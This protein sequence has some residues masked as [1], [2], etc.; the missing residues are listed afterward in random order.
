MLTVFELL[1]ITAVAATTV[2]ITRFFLFAPRAAT[3]PVP[4]PQAEPLSLLFDNGVLHHASTAALKRFS[5]VPGRHVWEDLRDAL[6]GQFPDLPGSDAAGKIKLRS[7][8]AG[9]PLEIE[10][11]WRDGLCWVHLYAPVVADHEVTTTPPQPS[12][13]RDCINTMPHPAWTTDAEGRVIWTNDAYVK[14]AR[15]IGNHTDTTKDDALF[16]LDGAS[17]PQRCVVVDATGENAWFEVVR[18]PT[19]D[20]HINHATPITGL[21]HA[22]EAQRTFVQ[23]LAKTFAHLPVGLAIFDR[24]G[25]LGIFNPAL[26]DL[27]GLQASFLATQ[28]TMLG[29]F[30]A[31]RENRRMPEPKNYQSWRQD[32][33]DVIAAASGG[34]YHETWS[35]E[36]GRTYAVQGRPHPD[37][38]TAFLI[39]DISADVTLSRSYRAEIEQFE[40][41][42][43]TVDEALVVF[44][45]SGILTFCN[46]AYRVMWGQTPEAAFADVTIHDAVKLWKSK[47]EDGTKLSGLIGFSTSIGPRPEQRFELSLSQGDKLR[48]TLKT[49]AADATAIRFCRIPTAA[50][51]P[52]PSAPAPA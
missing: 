24:E 52:V 27:S 25:Q 8:H 33:A 41:L 10:I 1:L 51:A 2:L 38:S 21:V 15:Q 44:S 23:T 11:S 46:D 29:F 20:G 5:F 9:D 50:P 31:L 30:D 28:P 48:C 3:A 14:L 6:L 22:E 13:A 7:A 32:I 39:E 49:L 35:L 19:P 12:P 17:D 42:L 26:V 36:D 16:V 40:A 4:S 18:H 37:G 34:Q 47:V 45:A 43:D